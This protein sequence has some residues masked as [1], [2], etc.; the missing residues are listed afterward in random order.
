MIGLLLPREFD[1]LEYSC[2][3]DTIGILKDRRRRSKGGG[4]EWEP[5]KI[6]GGKSAYIPN[7]TRRPSSNLSK[8]A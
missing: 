5:I 3:K 2:V 8:T 7:S 4:G 1:T 6:P